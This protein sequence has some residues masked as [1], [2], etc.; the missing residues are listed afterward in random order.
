[1]NLKVKI[2]NIYSCLVLAIVILI[3]LTPV[4]A[5]SQGAVP[6]PAVAPAKITAQIDTATLTMGERTTLHV[7]VLK[8]GHN[9]SVTTPIEGNPDGDEKLQVAGIE[10]RQIDVDSAD[11][12]NN[13]IQVRYDILLQPFN[14]GDFS[15]PPF[16]YNDGNETLSS[17]IVALKVLEPEIPQEMRD[18]LM[19]NPLRPPMSI[20]AKW[21]DWIPDWLTEYW[22]FI[23]IGLVLVALIATVIILYKKNGKYLLPRKKIVPPYELAMRRLDALKRSGLAE[24]GQN[25]QYYTELTEILRKY[26]GG[27][28]RI[29]ALEMTSTQ[30]LE[31]LEKN[32]ETAPFALQLKPMFTVADF[33]KFAKQQSSVDENIRSF[34]AVKEFIKSTRPVEQQ[35]ANQNKQQTS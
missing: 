8:N 10:V 13:R 6:T 27:R 29:Y 17:D 18:S 35:P 14:P 1:M 9:G 34:N 11:L 31:E 4:S 26:L 33:V 20:Q 24:K 15:I 7:E 22:Y 5:Q 12:G 23:L 21:Y 3:G 25:K 28:F 30:I 2:S 32:P 19:I 16:K